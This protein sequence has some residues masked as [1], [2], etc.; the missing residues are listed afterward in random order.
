MPLVSVL[1]ASYNHER[2]VEEAV[3]SIMSQTGVDF[4]LIVIDDGSKDKSPQ[5]LKRLSNEL[6]FKYVHRENRGVVATLNE[7]L[8]LASGKYFCTFA[9]DDI[10]PAGRLAEQSS[11]LESNPQAIACFGQIKAMDV[12][13]NIEPNFDAR[14]L[15]SIPQVTFE[16][17]FLGERELHGC[18]EMLKLQDFK[19][20]GG[21][22]ATIGQE[23]FPMMLKLLHKCS[24]LPVVATDCCHYR[25]H[26]NNMSAANTVENVDFLYGNMLD[27]VELYREHALY[28]KAKKLWK[29]RHFSALVNCSKREALKRLPSL[30]SCT[31]YFWLRT[32]K[33]FIPH[34]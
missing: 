12:N 14:Y 33:F 29:A 24:P 8:S 3:R 28:E 13:G 19:Q 5:I 11:Y 31:T 7:L 32:L 26:G 18:S 20:M 4:E 27:T 25:I 9:S 2:F 15:R 10:M 1:L 17:F 34:R 6:G 22:D 21:F 16:Q 23:D 30:A